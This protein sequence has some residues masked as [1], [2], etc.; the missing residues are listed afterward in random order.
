MIFQKLDYKEECVAVYANGQFYREQWPQ[1]L[2]GTWKYSKDTHHNNIEYASLYCYGKS[3][4]DMCPENLSEDWNA[5]LDKMKAYLCSFNEA[6]INLDD[7]CFYDLAPQQ[8]LLEHFDL[9]NEIT[10]H[11]FENFEKPKN[12]NFLLSIQKMICQISKQKLNLDFSIFEGKTNYRSLKLKK[13]LMSSK[14]QI[15]YN[16][17]GTKTGRLTTT[18]N[19]FPI[20]TLGKEYRSLIKPNND[21]FIELDYN[22]AELRTFLGLLG[23][24]Q[25]D[26]DIHTW[27]GKNVF[28]VPL[29][30]E[31]VKKK[32]FAWLYNPRAKN[33]RLENVFDKDKI[34]NKY[35]TDN[36]VKTC[37]GRSIEADDHH[38]LNYVIQSVTSD[39]VLERTIKI[40][41]ALKNR[42][43][44]VAFCIHDSIVLDF[45]K[46]DREIFSELVKIFENTKLGKFKVNLSMGKDFGNMKYIET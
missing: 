11:V 29:S 24:K 21:F 1:G 8:F 16:I 43:S 44:N 17:F 14:P 37:F 18:Q 19:S 36:V 25:P 2:T 41:D 35:Y 42:A 3:Y 40:I 45:K 39:L 20:L 12:Y 28:K 9:R 5:S 22:A 7:V 31:V 38:A 34:L 30:R 32:V 15:E 4:E 33:P 23:A 13:K 10:K 46:E 27:I 26:E 6:K